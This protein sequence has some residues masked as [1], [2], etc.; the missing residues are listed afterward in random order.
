MI[1]DKQVLRLSSISA[2]RGSKHTD[3]EPHVYQAFNMAVEQNLTF[4]IGNFIMHKSQLETAK[5]RKGKKLPDTKSM[6][7]YW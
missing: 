3:G 5:S 7:K 1:N 6:S 4:Y 2:T